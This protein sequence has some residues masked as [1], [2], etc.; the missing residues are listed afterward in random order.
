MTMGRLLCNSISDGAAAL[1]VLRF[2]DCG[3]QVWVSAV[4]L[5][6]VEAGMLKPVCTPCG[7]RVGRPIRIHLRSMDVLTNEER[8]AEAREIVAALNARLK[9]ADAISGAESP[10]GGYQVKPS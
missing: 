1:S 2:C 9:R 5:P 10:P 6:V 4:M 8:L 3:P 7:L